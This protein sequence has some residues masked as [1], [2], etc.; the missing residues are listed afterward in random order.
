M[1]GPHREWSTSPR[2]PPSLHRRC[3]GPGSNEMEAKLINR[4]QNKG[5][6]E[7]RVA[8]DQRV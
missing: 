7:T 3:I 5:V 4:H 1:D 6:E 2:D 8:M